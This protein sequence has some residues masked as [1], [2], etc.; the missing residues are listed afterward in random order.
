MKLRLERALIA[1]QKVPH[2]E[3]ELNSKADELNDF[4]RKAILTEK[5]ISIQEAEI[6]EIRNE[7]DILRR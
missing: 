2:L 7:F 1:S 4:K 3:D 6:K 5:Q